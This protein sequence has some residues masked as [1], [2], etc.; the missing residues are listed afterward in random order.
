M[1]ITIQG[2]RI[3]ALTITAKGDSKITGSYELVGSNDNTLA[4]QSFNGYNDIKYVIS[5][6]TTKLCNDFMSAVRSDISTL[7]G[8]DPA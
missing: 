4:T 2:I 8:L 6:A 1:A 3:P 5:P 7:L